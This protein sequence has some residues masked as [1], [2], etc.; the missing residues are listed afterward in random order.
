M[1]AFIR[2]SMGALWL[3]PNQYFSGPPGSKTELSAYSSSPEVG[4]VPDVT[5]CKGDMDLQKAEAKASISFTIF[6]FCPSLREICHPVNK[7]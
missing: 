5:A 6:Y 3:S 7:S 4:S 1:E 2:S